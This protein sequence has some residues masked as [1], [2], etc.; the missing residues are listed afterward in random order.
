MRGYITTLKPN[1]DSGG[2]Y[3]MTQIKS[4][5]GRGEDCSIRILIPSIANKHCEIRAPINKQV[6]AIPIVIS[7]I[8]YTFH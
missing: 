6:S 2:S 4:V 3:P 8:F 1:G 5:I 7:Y